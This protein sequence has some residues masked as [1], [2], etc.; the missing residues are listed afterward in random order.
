M[1]TSDW[2]KL[3]SYPQRPLWVS[4]PALGCDVMACDLEHSGWFSSVD[5]TAS[6]CS[7][8]VLF[9]LDGESH[10]PCCTVR[11]R[12][13]ADSK[14][15]GQCRSTHGREAPAGSGWELWRES[16]PAIH[17]PTAPRA[18]AP[19]A[20]RLLTNAGPL[21]QARNRMV[22]GLHM[23]CAD[24]RGQR[25]CLGTKENKTWLCVSAQPREWVLVRGRRE[26]GLLPC[27]WEWKLVQP[28]WRTVRRFLSKPKTELPHGSNNPT[29]G[30]YPEKALLWKDIP[31]CSEQHY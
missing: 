30:V 12:G 6:S 24:T 14:Q 28:P 11:V 15:W 31:L 3:Q 29:P 23:H 22:C 27:G 13:P 7:C 10:G 17:P 25:P 2:R 5:G 20:V 21:A 19:G 1:S 18:S 9:F 26:G 4:G 16:P 8:C